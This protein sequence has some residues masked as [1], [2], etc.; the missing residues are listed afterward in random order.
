MLF[1]NDWL[2]KCREV[3]THVHVTSLTTISGVPSYENA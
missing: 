3:N 2:I 1:A